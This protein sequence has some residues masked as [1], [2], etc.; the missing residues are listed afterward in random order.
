MCVFSK[1]VKFPVNGWNSL[2]PYKIGITRGIVILEKGTA[3]MQRDISDGN[4]EMFIKLDNNRTDIAIVNRVQGLM[5][6]K[7][8][9]LS[10]IQ[11]LGPPVVVIKLYHYLHEK[12]AEL[13]PKITEILKRMEKQGRIEEINNHIMQQFLKK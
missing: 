13:V 5:T 6:I 9:N 11:T 1:K 4:D 10:D 12:N 2:K 3:G 7:K 8:L